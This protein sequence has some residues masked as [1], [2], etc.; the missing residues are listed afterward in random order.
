RELD[1]IDSDLAFGRVTAAADRLQNVAA[2]VRTISHGLYPSELTDGGLHAVLTQISAVPT[3]RFPPAVEITAF[4]AAD[5]DSGAS[6]KSEPG[7]LVIALSRPPVEPML[8]ARVAALG[9]TIQGSS[10]S[11]PVTG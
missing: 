4:L 3:R 7:R 6:M 11:L 9:G 2:D 5:G 8:V 10:I 1:V